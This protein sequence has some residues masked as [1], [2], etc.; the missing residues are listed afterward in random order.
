MLTKRTPGA[1]LSEAELQQ[2]RDAARSR[3]EGAAV[4][5]GGAAGGAAGAALAGEAIRQAADRAKR[6]GEGHAAAAV[7]RAEARIERQAKAAKRQSRNAGNPW[8][9]AAYSRFAGREARLAAQEVRKLR[10]KLPAS[11]RKPRS[12]V[13]AALTESDA[14]IRLDVL[15]RQ[16]VT[17]P[18]GPAYNKARRRLRELNELRAIE[19]SGFNTRE[20][21]A[22]FPSEQSFTLAL[23]RAQ[24]RFDA[25]LPRQGW[26]VE[27][28]QARGPK[29]LAPSVQQRWEAANARLTQAS[30]RK[31][32]ADTLIG[33]PVKPDDPSWKI[34]GTDGRVVPQR[35]MG[36]V[37][38]RLWAD[39]PQ[40]ADGVS[41]K[42]RRTRAWPS[43]DD[44]KA[45]RSQMRDGLGDRVIAFS[46]KEAAKGRAR[47]TE[48]RASAAQQV[49]RIVGM[50][51]RAR[52]TGAAAGV[53]LGALAAY[54]AARKLRREEAM[55]KADAS[56]VV[57]RWAKG[58]KW[59]ATGLVRGLSTAPRQTHL[60][61]GLPPASWAPAGVYRIA[62]P[63]HEL[64]GRTRKVDLNLAVRFARRPNHPNS[65]RLRA[66]EL[67][68]MADTISPRL[69]Q[70]RTFRRF[71]DAK[72]EAFAARGYQ[73]GAIARAEV[74][75]EIGELVAT[76]NPAVR[77]MWDQSLQ[78]LPPGK[79]AANVSAISHARKTWQKRGLL[80]KAAPLAKAAPR[81]TTDLLAN[82]LGALFRAWTDNPAQAGDRESVAEAI[83]PASDLFLDAGDRII[84]PPGGD[85]TQ[86]APT[87]PDP[88]YLINGAFDAR[89]PRV[90]QL[91]E[92]YSFDLIR[93][94]TDQSREAVRTALQL[95]A[96]T[97]A[98]IPE[99]ARLIRQSVGLSPGQV[100][101]VSSYRKQLETLDARALGRELRDG[102]YDK[103]IRRAI[104]T[105]KPLSEDQVERMVDAY[106]RRTLAYRATTIARTEGIRAANMGSLA[107]VKAMLE[108]DPTLTVEKTWIATKDGRERSTHHKL[109]GQVVVGLDTP[110]MVQ[111]D[112]GMTVTIRYPHDEM[113]AASETVNCRCTMGFRV[114][115]ATERRAL[116]AE[117]V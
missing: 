93:N 42:G 35:S 25:A 41:W 91:L 45:M 108:A 37:A 56:R 75:A 114:V 78:G 31:L 50:K 101:W 84:Q 9:M 62:Q 10:S 76:R 38:E 20:L 65:K 71:A 2:R 116:V 117:A 54:L 24:T 23:Q 77:R 111:D 5:A 66:H 97:G 58:T 27:P 109:D 85:S 107:Q 89:N 32:R 48:A 29:P 43:Q 18:S 99:Q 87:G 14:A 22:R 102:R 1:P 34:A 55:E 12:R 6:R 80:H 53:G 49:R 103:P 44:L 46:R 70:S 73:P 94:I 96:M 82:R 19:A 4:L 16:P 90:E 92:R 98:T 106:H 63:Q 30:D 74:P 115:R 100:A 51:G 68:H 64:K 110:F 72:G 60:P 59:N 57:A 15:T 39:A 88:R 7:K 69:E 112:Q 113:A 105:G 95:G 104:E 52:I 13:R 28:G 33:K 86:S 3:W 11:E 8:P 21:L 81:A 61:Q 47:A 36:P 40:E 79:R 67:G 17:L 26:V 83:E